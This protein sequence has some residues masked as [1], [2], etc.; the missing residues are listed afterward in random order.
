MVKKI[1]LLLVALLALSLAVSAASIVNA[2]TLVYSVDHEWAQVFINQDGTIDLTY[3]ITL[4]VTSGTLHSYDA[5]QPKQD[6]TIGSAVDQY[7]NQL[8]TYKYTSDVASV[9]FK[10]PLFVFGLEML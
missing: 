2:Q 6:F 4:T 10:T 9:D 5:G 3:N 8:H 7:G 1:P